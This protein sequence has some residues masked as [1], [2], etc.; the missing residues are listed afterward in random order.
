MKHQ[1][2]TAIHKNMD[3][4]QVSHRTKI[5]DKSTHLV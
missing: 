3:E 4:P 1:Q 2:T 5:S